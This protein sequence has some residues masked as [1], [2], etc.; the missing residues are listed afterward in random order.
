MKKTYIAPTIK[1]VKVNTVNMMCTSGF[2][3]ALGTNEV[4]GSAALSRERG[5]RTTDDFDDLW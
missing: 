3:S 4:E 2:N 5:S 1:M